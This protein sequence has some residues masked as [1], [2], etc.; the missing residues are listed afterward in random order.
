MSEGQSHAPEPNAAAWSTY[1]INS[2]GEVIRGRWIRGW[3][4][5]LYSVY[6]LVRPAYRQ[7]FAV[8]TEFAVFYAAFLILYF[9]VAELTGRRQTVAFVLFFLHAFLYYSLNHDAYVIFVYP[10]AMLCLFVSRLRTL[11]LVLI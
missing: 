5:L 10:F 2:M 7:S 9:L 6:F 1:I 4:G 11:F 8:W 3:V